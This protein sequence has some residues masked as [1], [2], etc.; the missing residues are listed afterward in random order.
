M[1]W[2]GFLRSKTP[3]NKWTIHMAFRAEEIMTGY[4]FIFFGAALDALIIPAIPS[5]RWYFFWLLF[6]AGLVVLVLGFV[7]LIDGANEFTEEEKRLA[8]S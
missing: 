3:R 6:P 2:E 8:A 5:I 7:L 4:L 1:K